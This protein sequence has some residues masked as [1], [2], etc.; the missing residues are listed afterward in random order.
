MRRARPLLA[1][2]AAAPLAAGLAAA[3]RGMPDLGLAV[4]LLAFPASLALVALGASPRDGRD[5]L[6]MARG[7]GA[8]FA[9]AAVLLLGPGLIA[10]S[11]GADALEWQAPASQAGLGVLLGALVMGLLRLPALVQRKEP[12]GGTG[13]DRNLPHEA[14]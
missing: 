9:L 10:A 12:S 6:G 7:L 2:L 4:V 5:A 11:L 8:A 13:G 14:R 1:A 3:E